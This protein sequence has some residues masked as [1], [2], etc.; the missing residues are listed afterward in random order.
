MRKGW[1]ASFFVNEKRKERESK[2]SK[3]KFCTG[4]RN[5]EFKNKWSFQ[6]PSL[7]ITLGKIADRLPKFSI[8]HQLFLPISFY[9]QRPWKG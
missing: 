8:A 3:N 1:T 2:A 7:S 4:C 6:H 9:R 5:A